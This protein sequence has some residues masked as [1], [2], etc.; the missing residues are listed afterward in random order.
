MSTGAYL[1]EAL[2]AEGRHVEDWMFEGAPWILTRGSPRL[3]K[4]LRVGLLHACHRLY[5]EER[6]AL[7][8]PHLLDA[9]WEHSRNPIDIV[10]PSEEALD[11]LLA[12]RERIDGHKPTRD[13]Y[14][15]TVELRRQR[16]AMLSDPPSGPV[17]VIEPL[18]IP[19]VW[20]VAKGWPPGLR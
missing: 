9:G 4:A 3:K 11:M 7:D 1:A 13:L 19:L 6:A 16:K 18:G 5:C 8:L 20:T 17:L 14:G 15:P 10:N 12:L 2:A